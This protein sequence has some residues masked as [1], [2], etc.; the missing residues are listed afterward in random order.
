MRDGR[1]ER[2]D[3][4]TREGPAAAIGDGHRDHHRQPPPRLLEHLLDGDQRG[5]GVERVEDGLD[6]QQ[7]D[8]ALDQSPDLLGVG[9]P[10]LLERDGAE[11]R[12][13]HVRRDREGAVGRPQVAR[14]EARAPGEPCHPRVC[15]AARELRRRDVQLEDDR[16]EVV[17]GLGDG[18]RRE[19]VGLD[20]VG[21]GVQVGLVDG[22][23]DVRPREDQQIVVPL[24]I[25]RM[26]GEARA[27]VVLLAEAVTLDH[28]PHRSFEDQDAAVELLAQDG[29]DVGSGHRA[30]SL[31][32]KAVTIW[33][34]G[35][36]CSRDVTSQASTVSPACASIRFTRAALNPA[37]WWP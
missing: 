26:T 34:C 25:V 14:D 8:A 12:V 15:H 7:V 10:H 3:G 23:D 30:V 36:R 21:A 28:G 16:L 17:V 27:A 20:D 11:R 4:L 6:Q 24:Q 37:C 32:A 31:R 29:G 18:R 9:R 13:V 19:G 22:G 2:L 35:W 33:K 1:V 5:L